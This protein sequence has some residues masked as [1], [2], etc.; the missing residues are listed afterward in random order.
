M[1]RVSA[2]LSRTSKVSFMAISSRA[3]CST[4]NYLWPSLTV[5]A[6]AVVMRHRI[7]ATMVVGL[8]IACAG[9]V[10]ACAQDGGTGPD[11][12][13]Q[14]FL[15]NPVSYALGLA[16]ALTWALYWPATRVMA[17]G[18]DALWFFM[19]LS[20]V[21]FWLIHAANAPDT[22]LHW[23]LAAVGQLLF[24]AAATVGGYG[25][26][27]IAILKGNLKLLALMANFTPILAALF[28]SLWLGAKLPEA[29][30]IGGALIVAGSA[31]AGIGSSARP[32]TVQEESPVE[33][34][35]AGS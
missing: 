23:S 18:H 1:R 26:W 10:L 29:F 27:N 33:P 3:W 19:S 25:L 28:A 8:L 15:A 2:A 22:H 16:A 20:A 5:V 6:S 13:V 31:V 14:N 24:A 21:A 30:W 35:R 7:A 11:A 9:A 17:K 32:K 4:L 12:F 34:E